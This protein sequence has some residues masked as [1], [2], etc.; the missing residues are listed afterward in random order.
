MSSDQTNNDPWSQTTTQASDDP[1]G[2]ASDTSASADWLNSEAVE[3]KAF[4][5]LNPFEEA[6]LPVDVWVESGLNWLVEHGRPLFQAVRVP[7]D[8]ILSSFETA[9]VSTPAPFML[10]ILFLLAWQFSNLKLGISTAVSLLVIGLIGAWSEAM[11]TL[12]LV[13]TSVFFCLLIG[14]PMGI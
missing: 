4:D 2:Q 13:M 14:L 12:S 5:P 8:F 3:V 11:T 6:V 9:L 10:M 7:I 1:W